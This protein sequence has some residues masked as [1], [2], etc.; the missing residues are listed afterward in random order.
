MKKFL[1]LFL[2][3]TTLLF[4][5]SWNNTVATSISEPNAE[6]M[7]LFTNRDGNHLIVQNSNSSN[8]LKYYLLNS[9]GSIVRS[10]TIETSGSAEFPNISGDNDKVY[11]IYKLGSNL[12]LKKSTNAGQ[13]W[14]SLDNQGIG[15]NTCNG[16]D[17]V[18]DYR[19]VHVVYAMK[20]N[21]SD[22]ETYYRNIGSNDIWSNREDVTDYGT[23]VGGFP[24][25]AV[26]SNRIHVG[27]NNGNVED[28][29]ENYYGDAKTRD[30]YNSTWQTPQSVTLGGG[31]ESAREKVQVR[32]DKLYN[33]FYDLWC[34]L[35][36]CGYEL[37]VKS[38]NLGGTSWSSSTSLNSVNNPSQFMGAEQTAN[39]ELH[40]VYGDWEI[41]HK[42]YNGA[43]WSS[44][45]ELTSQQAIGVT[46]GFSYVSND[47]Y[48]IWKER[49]ISNFKYAQ[50]DATP[51]APT[52]FTGTNYNNRPKLTWDKIEPDIEYF[53]IWRR[54]NAPGY[55]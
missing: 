9:S 36:N 27:Y 43:V 48:C 39:S 5:Q 20:D 30:K 14:A 29:F 31:E 45:Y 32:T 34:D 11:I 25:I 7:D 12:K 28:P 3:M 8:S 21:G 41:Y 13:N 47:L 38:R 18:Y 33:F 44:E 50:Y 17:I 55:P 1:I 51:L 46:F 49:D 23:E 24:T 40:V 10:A 37:K 54:F 4:S 22:Y 15:S 52:N 42:Y 53:E 19:G 2:I 6:K 16:V 26:S 35:G